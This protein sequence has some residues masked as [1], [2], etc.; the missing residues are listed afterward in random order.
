MIKLDKIFSIIPD[1]YCWVL[2]KEEPTGK[3]NDKGIEII[4]RDRWYC[5]DLEAVFKR[6]R[7]ESCKDAETI[8]QLQEIIEE[9]NQKIEKYA[10]QFKKVLTKN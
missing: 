6:Y 7:N 2:L 5:A 3:K 9:S 1:S 10:I 8:E 4:S